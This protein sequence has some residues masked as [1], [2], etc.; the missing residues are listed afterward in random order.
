V[1]G[2]FLRRRGFATARKRRINQM[3]K[4]IFE[5]ARAGALGIV[6]FTLSAAEVSAQAATLYKNP[7]CT[8]CEDYAAYL[9]QHGFQVTVQPTHDLVTISREAGIPETF[10]GCHTMFID[11]YVVSGHVPVETVN[12][13]L[14][15]RPE[16]KGVTLPG[17]PLGSPGMAG[18]KTEPL[19]IYTVTEGAPEVY[20]V[21]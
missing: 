21:E 18:P 6:A 15:E 16:I 20:A 11:N 19:T 5:L 1:Y 2:R 8:C 12:R 13:L 4:T 10:Q 14:T 9:R 7:E 3:H 17:M